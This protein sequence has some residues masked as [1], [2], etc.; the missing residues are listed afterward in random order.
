MPVHCY[1]WSCHHQNHPQNTTN[2]HWQV[3]LSDDSNLFSPKRKSD[4]PSIWWSDYGSFRKSWRSLR[5]ALPLIQH[6]GNAQHCP[7]ICV[8]AFRSIGQV[9]QVTSRAVL[10]CPN[11]SNI[12][13]LSEGNPLC[14]IDRGSLRL[15][16]TQEWRDN[17]SYDNDDHVSEL[18]QLQSDVCLTVLVLPQDSPTT[19]IARESSAI[20]RWVCK[21]T[22]LGAH[23]GY[24]KTALRVEHWYW[25]ARDAPC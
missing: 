21:R 17:S 13:R 22:N 15:E 2:S 4:E 25:P 10:A 24:G 12:K 6:S 8:G 11:M 1:W 20:D 19:G 9:G 14:G 7:N 23:P 3:N 16:Q 18:N 5:A